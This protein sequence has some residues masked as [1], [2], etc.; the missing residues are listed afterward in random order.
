MRLQVVQEM[1]L[2]RDRRAARP[3]RPE[4]KIKLPRREVVEVLGY[5]TTE[6]RGTDGHAAT[7]YTGAQLSRTEN[8][9]YMEFAVA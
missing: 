2:I 1:S 3:A 4:I 8:I 6:K 9:R 5:V 7:D